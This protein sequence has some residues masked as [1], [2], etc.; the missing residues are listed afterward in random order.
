MLIGEMS[1]FVDL[2]QFIC[3]E[4]PTRVFASALSLNSQ[5][6]VDQDNLSIVV[7]FDGGS[8]GTLCYNTVGNGK[9]GKERLEV[10]GGGVVAILDDFRSLEI[11]KGGKVTRTKSANQDKGQEREVSNTIEAF[12]TTG[13]AP[14]PFPELVATMKV[15]FAARQSAATGEAVDLDVNGL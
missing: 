14:I 7:S 11:A 12:R 3:G 2:M 5:K 10:Y 13:S 8:V 6:F 4:R 1:H 15:I 9:V